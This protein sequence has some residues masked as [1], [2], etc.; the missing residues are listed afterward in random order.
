MNFSKKEKEKIFNIIK[1]KGYVILHDFYSEEKIEK[2]KKTLVDMLNYIKSDN[3]TDLQEKYYQIKDYNPKL[4]GHFYDMCAFELETYSAIHDPK[5]IDLAK[6]YFNT[7]TIFSGRAAIHIHDSESERALAPHQETNTF[8]KD[9]LL[10]WTPLYDAIDDQGGLYIYK[11]SHKHGIQRHEAEN[12]LGSTQI[13]S[14]VYSKFERVRLEVK[15]R[16]ALIV[17]NAVIHASVKAEKKGFARF[18]L[19]ERYCPLQKIPYLRKENA[20]MKIPYPDR[21]IPAG[22]VDYEA[23]ED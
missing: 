3:V 19:S 11:D 12:K 22:D 2:I 20:P 16:S 8:S 23:I 1:E 18:I 4:L 14:E 7:T 5:L 9:N 21:R 10:L 13:D 15:A 6:G 17:H